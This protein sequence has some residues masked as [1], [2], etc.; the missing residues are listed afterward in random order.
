MSVFVCMA[1]GFSDEE[2]VVFVCWEFVIC[3]GLGGRWIWKI[4]I[5]IIFNLRGI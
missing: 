4:S 3:V 2:G 1:W 5:E